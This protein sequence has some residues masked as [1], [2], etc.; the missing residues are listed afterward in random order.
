MG[1]Y[2]VIHV[3]YKLLYPSIRVR[4]APRYQLGSGLVLV[5]V[6]CNTIAHTVLEFGTAVSRFALNGI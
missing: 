5:L 1:L 3:M 4:T 6:T 2:V